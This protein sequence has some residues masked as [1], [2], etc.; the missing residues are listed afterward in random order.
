VVQNIDPVNAATPA[1]ELF[2]ATNLFDPMRNP[3]YLGNYRIL[4]S[5]EFVLDSA[6]SNF[7]KLEFK[8]KLGF[9]IKFSANGGTVADVTRNNVEILVWSDQAANP[10]TLAGGSFRFTFSDQ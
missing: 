9:P 1:A 8:L 7:L 4:Y 6:R 5:S 3:N 10:P 2:S